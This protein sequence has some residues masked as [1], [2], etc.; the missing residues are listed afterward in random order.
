MSEVVRIP[1]SGA[2]GIPA[3]PVRRLPS[4]D[5]GLLEFLGSIG[6]DDPVV[7][8]VEKSMERT[9]IAGHGHRSAGARLGGASSP[10]A[11]ASEAGYNMVVLMIAVTLL[12]VFTAVSLPLWTQIM[13]REKEA[14][15]IFRGWQYAE[16]IRVFQQRHGRYPTRLE[17]LMEV[18]PRSIRRLWDDPMTESG[19]WGLVFQGDVAPP[20][21]Q[22][23]PLGGGRPPGSRE[24]GGGP[25]GPG[26]GGGGTGETRA[27][28]SGEPGEERTVGPI[29]G[30]RSLSDASSLRVLFGE[31]SYDRWRFTVDKLAQAAS[32]GG[33][34]GFGGGRSN[35]R[36]IIPRVEWLGKPFPGGLQPQQGPGRPQGRADGRQGG[37]P[38]D[39]G[40]E[41]QREPRRR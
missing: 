30:V 20:G 3:P 6:S 4:A 40:P 15:L 5:N 41:L 34:V 26:R 27:P 12:S 18:K 39:R 25:P 9:R 8:S 16:A 21:Q 37:G 19:E 36:P 22:G 1:R 24:G 10:A 29:V 31:E 7:P 23:Q 33:Q 28:S 38:A 11:R 14:E 35:P 17:E 32:G 13:K 2:P